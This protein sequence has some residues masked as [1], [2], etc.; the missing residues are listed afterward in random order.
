[1]ADIKNQIM[2]FIKDPVRDRVWNRS[3]MKS[4]TQ[5]SG[6]VLSLIR[7]RIWDMVAFQIYGQLRLR[8]SRGAN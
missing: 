7:M 2:S 4:K 1:M 3:S 8:R 5:I 6:V